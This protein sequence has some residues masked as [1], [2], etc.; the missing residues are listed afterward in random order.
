MPPVLSGRPKS[1]PYCDRKIDLKSSL[2]GDVHRMYLLYG[3][4]SAVGVRS[5]DLPDRLCGQK[6]LEICN[7]SSCR[8]ELNSIDQK[9][10]VSQDFRNA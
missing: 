9:I 6:S 5:T 4:G 10:D 8:L 1:F 7:F 2:S 3:E